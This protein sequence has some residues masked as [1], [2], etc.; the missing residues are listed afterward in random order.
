MGFL[1]KVLFTVCV[2]SVNT[3][4]RPNEKKVNVDLFSKKSDSKEC[5]TDF[6]CR[7]IKCK[8]NH[9]KNRQTRLILCGAVMD[10]VKEEVCI[11]LLFIY[12][13]LF[14]HGSNIRT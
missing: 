12:L 14:I 8:A 11:Y 10:E 4:Q 13:T 7:K 9:N 3:L 5:K 2:K 1:S 6:E